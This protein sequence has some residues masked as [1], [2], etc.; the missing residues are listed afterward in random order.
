[1]IHPVTTGLI[2]ITVLHRA[3]AGVIAIAVLHRTAAGLITVTMLHRSA[4]TRAWLLVVRGVVL[5][6]PQSLGYHQQAHGEYAGNKCMSSVL[7]I[8]LLKMFR[9]E[10]PF[11]AHEKKANALI[12][13][14]RV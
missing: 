7:H 11:G 1:V 12:Y 6:C 14:G 10:I 5:L 4:L 2:A 8:F 9:T 3:T 13:H